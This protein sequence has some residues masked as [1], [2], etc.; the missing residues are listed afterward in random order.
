VNAAVELLP[1][2]FVSGL[3]VFIDGVTP[4]R[5]MLRLFETLLANCP[6]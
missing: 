2:S 4:S 1:E 3:P 5:Q 6:P